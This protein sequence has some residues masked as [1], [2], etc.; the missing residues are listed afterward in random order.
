MPSTSGICT[1]I[2]MR[3]Y[4]VP[5]LSAAIQDSDRHLA[6]GGDH[7][8]MP[9]P[10]QQR[11]ASGSA[12]ISLSSATSTDS[13]CSGAFRAANRREGRGVVRH[14]RMRGCSAFSRAASEAGAQ[15]LDQI[16]AEALLL[17]RIQ[18]APLRRRDHDDGAAGERRA[19]PRRARCRSVCADRVVDDHAHATGVRAAAPARR[20][21]REITQV[22][23]P[24]SPSRRAISEVSIA[25]G[26][27]SMIERPA[28]S[29]A[30]NA[31]D[32]RRRR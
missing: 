25:C 19:R 12:L 10:H 20:R 27:T 14:D 3:S 24:H 7:R 28:R 26:D 29:G 22:C 9:K 8:A 16:V 5:A 13:D 30:A 17:Q 6:I 18:F 2:R 11:R 15:R 31:G 1:S 21:N 32:G 23:A 4:G